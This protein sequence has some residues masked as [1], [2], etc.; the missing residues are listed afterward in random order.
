MNSVAFETSQIPDPRDRHTYSYKAVPPIPSQIALPI[1][2]Q[3]IKYKSLTVIN[4]ILFSHKP[5]RSLEALKIV[6]Q[7]HPLLWQEFT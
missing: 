6:S 5:S 2:D 7:K 3:P 4:S 1:G